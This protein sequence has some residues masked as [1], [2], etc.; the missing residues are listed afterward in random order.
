M[1]FLNSI[2]LRDSLLVLPKV[3]SEVE[4]LARNDTRGGA[5]DVAAGFSLRI[6]SHPK[7]CGYICLWV[8]HFRR[9]I[10]QGRLVEDAG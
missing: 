6:F 9:R 10:M 7:G 5:I 1:K 2:H 8:C 4:G 3:P